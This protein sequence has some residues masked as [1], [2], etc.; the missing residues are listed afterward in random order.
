MKIEITPKQNGKNLGGR[1]ET[2]TT[3]KVLAC[4]NG[5]IYCALDVQVYKSRSGDGA[6]PIYASAWI[7]KPATDYAYVMRTA[8]GHGK[9]KGYGYN[10]IDAAIID[11]AISTA[12]HSAGVVVNDSIPQ[13][14]DNDTLEAVARHLFSDASDIVTV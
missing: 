3:R 12:L 5:R 4:V 10:K 14:G 8:S 11:A 13:H 1:Y 2:I 7:N 9:A 6:S